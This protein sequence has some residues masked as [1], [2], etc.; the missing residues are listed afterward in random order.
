MALKAN[1]EMTFTRYWV[2]D[3]GVHLA[4]VASDPGAGMDSDYTVGFSHAE[5]ASISTLAQFRTQVIARLQR[6]YRAAAVATLL[7]GLIGQKVSV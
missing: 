2:D 3:G 1:A 5:M 4:F 7:D 6:N